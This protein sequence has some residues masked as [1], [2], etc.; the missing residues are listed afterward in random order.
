MWKAA[1]GTN[2]NLSA[3]NDGDDDWETDPD[4][5]N[6]VTEQE[7]RWGSTTIEGSGRTAGSINMEQLR[8]ETEAADAVKKKKDMDEGPNASFGYG[9][10]FGVE[11]DRMDKSAVGHDHIEKLQKHA[12]QKDYAT[13]FGGK[14]G[15]QTDR[16]DKSAVNWDHKEKIEKHASQKDYAAGFGGKFGVE[17]DRQDKS[18][19]GWDHVEKVD[20]HESQ[21]DYSVGF[22]GKFGVQKDRQ[23]KSAV[24]WDHHEAPQKHESQVDHKVGFGGK[25]GVQTDR[26]DKS[27]ESFGSQP[28]KIGT[29]YDR[30]KPDIAGAKPSEMRAK[31]ESMNS[32]EGS[33]PPSLTSSPAPRKVHA[34]AAAFTEQPK[35]SESFERAAP[36][37]L[38]Q[39][40]MAFLHNQPE[41]ASV[42]TTEKQPGQLDKSKL[43][44][45]N[46]PTPET[47][48]NSTNRVAE[49]IQQLR[50]AAQS[51]AAYQ[52]EEIYPEETQTMQQPEEHAEVIPEEVHTQQIYDDVP[53]E[54]MQPEQ[55]DEYQ[56]EIVDTMRTAIALYDYA[57]AAEDEISFD[58]EDIITHVEL[59]DEGWWRGMCKGRYGL[60]PA[61][62]VK[63]QE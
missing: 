13:G 51:Q 28:A 25:F 37:Q 31:F 49:E 46:S 27:A 56:D 15:V 14:F 16:V 42:P 63:L 5:V 48:S 43:A 4:F 20:K 53:G 47:T 22:G 34:K 3:Q 7:Q 8:R 50:Q 36:K 26:M 60:F 23:D 40:K 38:D 32:Q 2:V 21:K 11:K 41:T 9:G 61:N 62:Y 59:I 12:S 30:V 58:P 44:Q 10:K 45:F 17:T 6:N 55:Y 33:K 57:A 29:N 18:A 1:V 52:E 19:V 24:G 39:T 54:E 35:A